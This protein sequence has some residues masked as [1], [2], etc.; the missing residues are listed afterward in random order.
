MSRHVIDECIAYRSTLQRV[1]H[2]QAKR[3]SLHCARMEKRTGGPVLPLVARSTPHRT[4]AVS[5]HAWQGRCTAAR[6]GKP[7]HGASLYRCSGHLHPGIALA[8]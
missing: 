4:S 5:R 8:Q 7:M 3:P 1:R 6:I 2:R